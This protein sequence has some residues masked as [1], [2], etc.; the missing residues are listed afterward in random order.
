MKAMEDMAEALSHHGILGQKW[1]VRRYQNSD[2]T[3]TEAGRARLGRLQSRADKY[4]VKSQ[5]AAKKVPS[6]YLTT[7]GEHKQKK[8]SAKAIAYEGKRLKAQ[9]KADKFE[10]KLAKAHEKE[11]K[12]IDDADKKSMSEQFYKKGR[13][14][15]GSKKTREFAGKEID[16]FSNAW[17]EYSDKS[18]TKESEKLFNN[19]MEKNVAL[20][21]KLV[22]DIDVP[23]KRVAEYVNNNGKVELTFK[24]K[25]EHIKENLNK[26]ERELYSKNEKLRDIGEAP[27]DWSDK[28]LSS[29]TKEEKQ[30]VDKYM[31]EYDKYYK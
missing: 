1:G 24:K 22:S 7:I 19:Y 10:E 16:E 5:K 27:V 11:V 28:T 13:Y 26:I 23:S 29:L 17:K 31:E 14:D 6:S 20:M 30:L 12:K 21:N 18:D 4:A 15:L 9:N 8:Y 25:T 3:L 2:G